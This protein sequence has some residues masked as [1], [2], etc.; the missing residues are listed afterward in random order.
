VSLRSFGGDGSGEGGRSD[1]SGVAPLS[2]V[3]GIGGGGGFLPWRGWEG[4]LETGAS[5]A[6]PDSTADGTMSG[7]GGGDDDVRS[8]TTTTKSLQLVQCVTI[9]ARCLLPSFSGLIDASCHPQWHTTE[10]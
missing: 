2:S 1:A 9:Y 6:E 5:V 7:D 8:T 4:G 10:L 3:L